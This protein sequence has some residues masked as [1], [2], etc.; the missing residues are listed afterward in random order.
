M[1]ARLSET[2][3]RVVEG[4]MSVLSTLWNAWKKVGR[5]IGDVIGRVSDS[6]LTVRCLQVGRAD[7]G[8]LD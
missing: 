7:V 5:F 3:E 2:E 6:L 1:G 8:D 4:I